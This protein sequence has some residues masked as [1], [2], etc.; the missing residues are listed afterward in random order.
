MNNAFRFYGKPVPHVLEKEALLI[1]GLYNLNDLQ[2]AGLMKIHDFFKR[3]TLFDCSPYNLELVVYRYGSDSGKQEEIS[4]NKL[5]WNT[6]SFFDDAYDKCSDGAK[7]FSDDIGHK[8]F[9]RFAIKVLNDINNLTDYVNVG[10][11]EQKEDAPSRVVE[12]K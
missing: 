4:R 3:V 6:L 9:N 7:H 10:V 12:F 2:L 11:I 1:Q 5:P 8:F